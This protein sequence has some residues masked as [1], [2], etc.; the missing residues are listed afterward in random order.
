MANVVINASRGTNPLHRI[1]GH[2][3][4]SGT[5]QVNNSAFQSSAS[6]L[7][8]CADIA[9]AYANDYSNSTTKISNKNPLNRPARW[10]D[11]LETDYG[12]SLG[13]FAIS[14]LSAT[15]TVTVD[16]T[17]YSMGNFEPVVNGILQ[18]ANQDAA[19]AALH[20]VEG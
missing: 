1:T 13:N 16:G 4:G 17:D 7:D 2:P 9:H 3:S 5:W 10:R 14:A 20:R 12:A 18:M 11:I 19:R 6:A 15:T 8:A